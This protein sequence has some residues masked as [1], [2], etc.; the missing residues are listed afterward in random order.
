MD[1][2]IQ[3]AVVREDPLI[4]KELVEAHKP[5]HALLVGGGGCTAFTLSTLFPELKITVVDPN[6]A[7]LQLIT[8]KAQALQRLS[9]DPGIVNIGSEDPKGLNACGNFETLFHCLRDFWRSF[10]LRSDE[11]EHMFDNEKRLRAATETL[12]THRYWPVSFDL[13]FSEEMLT[14]MFGAAAIQHAPK[15][16]YPNYFRNCIEA[17]LARPDALE[18]PFLHHAILGHYLETRREAWPLYIQRPPRD[19]QAEMLNCKVHEV[20][21]FSPYTL[22]NLSNVFDWSDAERVKKIAG[23]LDAELPSGAVVIWRQLNNTESF[24]KH[25]QKLQFDSALGTDMLAR[26]RSLFHTAIKVGR[27]P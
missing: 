19:F 5:Q 22:V 3:F 1:N 6:Q 4:E 20:E 24:E 14:T 23:R 2:P 13:F 21:S 11:L 25:F 9:M 15:G 10:I 16:S 27:K 26:S 8:R 18:N 12:T 17:G 7:Q